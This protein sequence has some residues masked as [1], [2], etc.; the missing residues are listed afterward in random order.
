MVVWDLVSR[1][2]PLARRVSQP[3][4]SLFCEAAS[5]PSHTVTSLPVTPAQIVQGAGRVQA[6]AAATAAAAAAAPVDPRRRCAQTPP[7]SLHRGPD[8]Q[9]MAGVHAYGAVC[10]ET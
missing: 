7:L 6:A 8:C 4:H 3:F 5:S 10:A 2:R 1:H 9:Q